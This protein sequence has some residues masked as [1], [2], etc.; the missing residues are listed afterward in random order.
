MQ[1]P[2]LQWEPVGI[3]IRAGPRGRTRAARIFLSR[4]AGWQLHRGELG[5]RPPRNRGSRDGMDLLH[6]IAFFGEL[7]ADFIE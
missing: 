7:V 2:C 5:A 4:L 1:V 3:I 6:R